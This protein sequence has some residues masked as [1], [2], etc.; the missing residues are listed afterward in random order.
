MSAFNFVLFDFL[1][2]GILSIIDSRRSS[3]PMPVFALTPMESL[4]SIPII[5]LI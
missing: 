4:V 3:T 5:S 1:G 2:G